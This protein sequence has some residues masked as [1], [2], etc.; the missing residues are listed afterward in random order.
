MWM[1]GDAATRRAPA[2][3]LGQG[4]ADAIIGG[5]GAGIGVG[6][7]IL[8]EIAGGG[9][10]RQ[11]FIPIATK[12]IRAGLHAVKPVAPDGAEGQPGLR[13]GRGDCHGEDG[14]RIGGI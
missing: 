10:G 11:Q 4:D 6:E 7:A 1:S 13:R 9:G 5:E 14:G 12:Q 8:T 2:G 3:R